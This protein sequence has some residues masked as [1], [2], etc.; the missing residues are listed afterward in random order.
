VGSPRGKRAHALGSLH[1]HG[2]KPGRARVATALAGHGRGTTEMKNITMTACALIGLLA[3][4]PAFSHDKHVHETYSA[5]EPGDPKKPS[6]TVEVDMSEM[7]YAPSSIEVKRGEQIRF[8]IRNVGEEEHEFMLA[9]TEENLKHAED[10]Q[11]QPHMDHDDPNEVRLK[12][13]KSTELVW[14]FTKPGTFEYSCL[15]PG[16]RENGM[17]GKV[18]VK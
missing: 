7:K 13:K 14:K 18:T 3:A 6:R 10:M 17:I 2:F 1:D 12:P 8:V 4:T 16:H 15:I 9:T 11:K 5:G